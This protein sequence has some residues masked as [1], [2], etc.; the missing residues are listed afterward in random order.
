MA[1]LRN[2]FQDRVR[3]SSEEELNRSKVEI[4]SV[5]CAFAKSVIPRL[6]MEDYQEIVEL[7]SLRSFGQIKDGMNTGFDLPNLEVMLIFQEQKLDQ[8][9]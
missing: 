2:K 9:T 8:L 4:L 5:S 6:F 3:S 1:Q 7:E